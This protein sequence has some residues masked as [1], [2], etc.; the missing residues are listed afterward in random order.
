MKV[1]VNQYNNATPPSSFENTLVNAT[2]TD[3]IEQPFLLYANDLTG[4]YRLVL[5]DNGW[6]SSTLS[7]ASGNLNPAPSITIKD[8]ALAISF[9]DVVNHPSTLASPTEFHIEAKFRGQVRVS[10]TVTAG[11]ELPNNPL[12]DEITITILKLS[13]PDEIMRLVSVVIEAPESLLIETGVEFPLTE[14]TT[15]EIDKR[16]LR[17]WVNR[18]NRV[19]PLLDFE[20]T[21]VQFGTSF[22]PP[23]D[24]SQYLVLYRNDLTGSFLLAT[25]G[26]G[27]WDNRQSDEEGYLSLSNPFTLLH[28]DLSGDYKLLDKNAEPAVLMITDFDQSLSHITLFSHL[29]AQSSPSEFIVVARYKGQTISAQKIIASSEQIAVNA[30]TAFLDD[31]PQIDEVGIIITRL[32]QPG[33]ILRIENV[34][35][36]FPLKTYK[37]LPLKALFTSDVSV[38]PYIKNAFI[39]FL[40][41]QTAPHVTA[42][43][44]NSSTGALQMLPTSSIEAR[45]KNSLVGTLSIRTTSFIT[46][47]VTNESIGLLKIEETT[48]AITAYLNRPSTLYLR[49][50]FSTNLRNPHT[51][52]KRPERV[53]FGKVDVAWVNPLVA[54]LVTPVPEDTAHNARE[55]QLSNM[56]LAST[57]KTFVLFHNDLSGSFQLP[58]EDSEVG[59]WQNNL[60]NESGEFERP[61]VLPFTFSRRPITE[62]EVICDNRHNIIPVDFDIVCLTYEGDSI[63][64]EVRNNTSLTIP[65]APR[66]VDIVRLEVIV[67][68]INKPFMTPIFIEVNVGSIVTYYNE[69]LISMDI[70]EELGFTEETIALGSLS[71]NMLTVFFNNK[72]RRF[73]FNATNSSIAPNLRKNRKIVPWLGYHEA[74][75]NETDWFR[76]GTFWSYSWEIPQDGIYA[77]VVALDTIGLLNTTIFEDH[78]VFINKSL[79][80]IVNYI[81][82]DATRTIYSLVWHIDEVLHNVVV[83]YVW[84]TRESHTSALDKL[85]RAWQLNIWADRNGELQIQ[86]PIPPITFFD[87]WSRSTNIYEIRYPTQY[88]ATPNYVAIKTTKILVADNVQLI[89]V[90]QPQPV[91]AEQQL[92]MP[93]SAPCTD[94]SSLVTS[95]DTTAIYRIEV[96]GWGINIYFESAGTLNSVVIHGTALQTHAGISIIQKDDAAILQDG[97]IT[98]TVESPFIQD[99]GYAQSL[100]DSL[101]KMYTAQQFNA[102]VTYRGDA[103][104]TIT[105]PI[106]ISD[107][108]SP[109]V[110]YTIRNHSLMWNGGMSG[111]ASLFTIPLPEDVVTPS[112]PNVPGEGMTAYNAVPSQLINGIRSP[113]YNTFT[114]FDNDLTGN[115]KVPGANDE[116]GWWS[117]RVADELGVFST[118]ISCPFK[119]TRRL[120]ET[121]EIVCDPVKGIVP[122]DFDII[123]TIANRRT[124]VVWQVRGNTDLNITVAP[125]ATNVTSMEIV[126]YSIDKPLMTPMFT[127]IVF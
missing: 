81:L 113:S 2:P 72:D 23:P 10:Q 120:I 62:F 127:E 89:N 38:E 14:I 57:F 108:I 27:W 102:E 7:D 116:V 63:V 21:L 118:P 103:T 106:V 4:S 39:G 64:F 94:L 40:S 121:V 85:T 115:Y 91:W 19:T 60:S 20:D 30:V 122:I 110:Y 37:E 42:H 119:V 104:L 15:T 105:D 83:P 125:G 53:I 74:S 22:S 95:I 55:D 47:Y 73:F 43:L 68:K 36:G 26:M 12:V 101:F 114:L 69:D 8:F 86:V 48:Q 71:A 126:V 80:Y 66:Q 109:N 56:V 33:E 70:V 58:G 76:L 75:D 78:E 1:F 45:A 77:K 87:T 34:L 46:A 24:T 84:F 52:S 65:M 107:A 93:F 17:V 67:Y 100:A 111:T 97:H 18:H 41:I 28:N 13:R 31:I 82:T 50:V 112:A 92:S 98:K 61:V 5:N 124:P 88:A 49:G 96:Y 6:W 16:H 11:L 99:V 51:Y 3:F 29:S 117:W 25:L 32:S 123:F 9:L 44:K 35:L 59:W 90:S 54:D 79:Y